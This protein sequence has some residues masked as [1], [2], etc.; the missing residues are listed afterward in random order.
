MPGWLE[1]EHEC[2][3]HRM[4]FIR[5]PLVSKTCYKLQEISKDL[6]QSNGKYDGYQHKLTT[7]GN[8]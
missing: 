3:E 5:K 2:N 6:R 4:I 8:K 7:L 1:R